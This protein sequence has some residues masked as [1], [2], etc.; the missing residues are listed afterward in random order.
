[1]MNYKYLLFTG[2]ALVLLG[3]GL[4]LSDVEWYHYILIPG[5]GFKVAYLVIGL[6]NGTL[7][8]GRYL[9]M[10]FVGIAMVGAGGYLKSALPETEL[11]HW[12]MMSGFLLKAVSIV[13]MVVVG[14]RR[15]RVVQE[16]PVR[17]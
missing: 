16:L 1:M 17:Q 13:F 14:R 7:A 4:L 9:A 15:M 10:L 2:L 3:I 8:A 11:G 12:L 5:I 6:L